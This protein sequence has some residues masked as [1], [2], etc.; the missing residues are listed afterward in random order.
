MTDNSKEA[1]KKRA[2]A[3]LRHEER[4]IDGRKAMTEYEAQVLTTHEKTA[5]LK[6]LRLAQ[7]AQAQSEEPPPKAKV[8]PLKNNNRVLSSR[9]KN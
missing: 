5:R 4:V 7:E 2:D 6:A 9:P 1:L 8:R 3:R